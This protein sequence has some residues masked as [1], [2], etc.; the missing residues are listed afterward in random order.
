M[1]T[2]DTMG[3]V[4]LGMLGHGQPVANPSSNSSALDLPLLPPQDK[5]SLLATAP[6]SQHAAE[7]LSHAP[8]WAKTQCECARIASQ[9]HQGSAG[10]LKIAVSLATGLGR[11]LLLS[12]LHRRVKAIVIPLTYLIPGWLG[13]GGPSKGVQLRVV[14][15]SQE[16]DGCPL[17][18]GLR[19]VPLA[20]EVHGAG[21]HSCA[22]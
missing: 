5:E 11:E 9:G 15:L 10:A 3:A 16:Q 1:G 19:G 18:V 21:R 17:I 20:D 8:K 12:S 14:L 22:G 6:W 7:H 2:K 13:L 4:R